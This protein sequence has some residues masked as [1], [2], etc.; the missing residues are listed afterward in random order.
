[1]GY[2]LL[3]LEFGGMLGEKEVNGA[4]HSFAE[5]QDAIVVV[6]I[7]DGAV[8]GLDCNGIKCHGMDQGMSVAENEIWCGTGSHSPKSSK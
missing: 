2:V 7:V 4:M 1:M 6:G 8:L 3:K 5:K